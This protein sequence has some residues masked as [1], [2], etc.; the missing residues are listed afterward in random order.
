MLSG[1]GFILFVKQIP[2]AM[3]Y[4]RD[5]EGDTSFFQNDNYSSFSELG[6]ML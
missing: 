1:M 6:H 5:Y 2:H 4:D 3:S